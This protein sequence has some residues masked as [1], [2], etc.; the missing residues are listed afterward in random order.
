MLLPN[1]LKFPSNDNDLRMLG[2]KELSCSS[3]SLIEFRHA[4]CSRN[5]KSS[6]ESF[7]IDLENA[8]L[9]IVGL[10][11]NCESVIGSEIAKIDSAFDSC[12]SRNWIVVESDSD[13]GTTEVLRS[14]EKNMDLR[15]ISHGRL[16]D[17]Y[18]LRTD[19]LAYCRN[20]YLDAIDSD[21]RTPRCD[22]VVVA[23]LDGMNSSI[24]RESVRSCWDPKLDWDACFA[25]QAGTY[26]DLWALRHSSWCPGD[27]IKT[28]HFLRNYGMRE[29]RAREAAVNG[30]QITIPPESEPIEVDSAFGG[31]GIYKREIIDGCRY[32][33]KDEAENEI[34]EH[35]PFHA[36]MRER[37]RRLLIVPSFINASWHEHNTQNTPTKSFFRSVRSSMIMGLD[38]LKTMAP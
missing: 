11:R 30:L 22:F 7:V 23:D 16:R 38:A 14:L 28:Y 6:W 5:Q 26:Y 2:R 12:H 36:T 3:E 24:T 1:Q 13:D 35:V 34:C 18:P 8:A 20:S 4:V 32:L 9:T 27:H 31:L 21:P 17:R 29:H 37:D 25:N 15:M 33:G 19:R 10:A